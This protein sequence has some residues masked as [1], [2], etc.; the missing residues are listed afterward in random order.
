MLTFFTLL[1]VDHPG[2]RASLFGLSYRYLQITGNLQRQQQQ[3]SE[4]VV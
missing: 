1:A 3:A 2:R 4:V